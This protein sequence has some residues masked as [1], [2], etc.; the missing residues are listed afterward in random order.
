MNNKII[1]LKDAIYQLYCKEGRSAV[2]IS[3]LFKINRKNLGLQLKEWNFEKL[4]VKRITPSNKKLL[5]KYKSLILSRLKNNISLKDISTEIKISYI[6]IQYLY[7]LD[8]DLIKAVEEYKERLKQQHINRINGFIQKS[9]RNYEIQL[10]EGE[11]WKPI[12][13]YEGYEISNKGRIRHHTLTYN[14]YYLLKPQ[15]N[16][17]N[18]R[19]YIALCHDNKQEL[20]QVAR[21][22]GFNFCDG[23]SKINNTINHK[24]GNVQN[25]DFSN[26]EWVSQSD[27]NLHSYRVLNRKINKGVRD[28]FII[29]YKNKFTFKTVA[30][31]A[32]FIN[33]SETQTR[34]YLETPK[35]YNIK[36]INN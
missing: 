29:V 13:G 17:N 9:S 10:I 34:R 16:K 18:N 23:Y 6:K 3:K 28:K 12:L 15:S 11:I 30:A 22:V 5:N 19:L 32:R 25:N 35:K 33:K 26:L 2:Y 1:E 7:K 36:I 14:K 31:F 24:D 8:N 4:K 20:L 21:L 27:N